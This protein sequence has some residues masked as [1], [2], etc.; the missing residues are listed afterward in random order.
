MRSARCVAIEGTLMAKSAKAKAE[1]KQKAE[2]PIS[3][4]VIAL[5]N[6]HDALMAEVLI[7]RAQQAEREAAQ[8]KY[9]PLK[10][11]AFDAGMPYDQARSWCVKGL[12]DCIRDGKR[13]LTTTVSLIERR[14]RLSRK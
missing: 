9:V 11:A 7:F 3:P 8:P 13:W 1:A 4:E 5:Q 12:V 6:S 2:L 10:P 14:K